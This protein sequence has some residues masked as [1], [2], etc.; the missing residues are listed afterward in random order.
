[1]FLK[2]G[3]VVGFEVAIGGWC[4]EGLLDDCRDL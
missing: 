3:I 2:E 1:M 4:G